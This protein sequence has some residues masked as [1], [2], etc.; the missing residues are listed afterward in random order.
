M[1]FAP[2]GTEL[3]IKWEGAGN[4]LCDRTS[5]YG[6][7]MTYV[8]FVHNIIQGGIIEVATKDRAYGAIAANF[9]SP[10]IEN[11]MLLAF[12]N[13]LSMGKISR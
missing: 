9:H 12:M 13:L 11:V 5:L 3:K 4:N 1:S 8:L 7:G 6:F 10:N 2:R